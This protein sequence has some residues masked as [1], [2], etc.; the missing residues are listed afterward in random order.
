MLILPQIKERNLK[1]GKD[2]RK[3]GHG[4]RGSNAH[5]QTKRRT[6]RGAAQEYQF[7]FKIKIA[8]S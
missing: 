3:T 8:F 5:R 1:N 6:D 2:K 4:I 7:T